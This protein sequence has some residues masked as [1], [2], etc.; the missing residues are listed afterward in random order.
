MTNC[1][2]LSRPDLYII[3]ITAL[4]NVRRKGNRATGEECHYRHYFKISPNWTSIMGFRTVMSFL[5]LM[6]TTI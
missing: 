1:L 4:S 6:M 2:R 5:V 3:S